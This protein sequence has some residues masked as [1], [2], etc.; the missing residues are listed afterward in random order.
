M[1]QLLDIKNIMTKISETKDLNNNSD[2]SENFSFGSVVALLDEH[3]PDNNQKSLS[4]FLVM[5]LKSLDDNAYEDL[6]VTYYYLVRNN[7]KK[8]SLI[9]DKSLINYFHK[10]VNCFD[11]HR[12][13][14]YLAVKEEKRNP[15][16]KFKTKR[17][18]TL[19]FLKTVNG[20]FRILEQEFRNKNFYDL[21]SLAYKNKM[22]YRK[23]LALMK[24]KYLKW[25]GYK[26]WALT[27]HYGENFFRWGLTGV[28]FIISIT[29]IFY[30]QGHF[31]LMPIDANGNFLYYHEQASEYVNHPMI[32][33]YG[34]EHI[35][36]N[37]LYFSVVTFTT[38][39]YGDILPIT[40]IEKSLTMFAVMCGYVM[41]GV[42]M[43]LLAKKF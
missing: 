12:K 24:G 28:L 5:R 40:M 13:N 15:Q 34:S 42:F 35:F 16:T 10:M 21:E 4:K 23:Q 6:G 41:L 20:Y 22:F 14:L 43:T 29:C 25:L 1:L 39:G 7:L 31:S 27:S 19:A 8:N 11:L 38:L 2:L 17:M 33:N 32:H 36:L 18:Q 3:N 26:I 37:Y 9:E 30:I